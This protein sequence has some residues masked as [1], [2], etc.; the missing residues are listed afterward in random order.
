MSTL[1][2]QI[3]SHS[4]TAALSPGIGGFIRVRGRI[5]ARMPHARRPSLDAPLS[6]VTKTTT[7]ARSRRPRGRQPRLWLG[8]PRLSALPL[9]ALPTLRPIRPLTADLPSRPLLLLRRTCLCRQVLRCPVPTVCS[10][11]TTATALCQPT[12]ATICS[13]AAPLLSRPRPTSPQARARPPTQTP[14]AV[15]CPP[16]P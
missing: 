9:L 15:L 8:M 5:N 2:I 6:L 12:C 1:L 13:P 3:C 14:M 10:T 4:V 7:P 16:T 11:H